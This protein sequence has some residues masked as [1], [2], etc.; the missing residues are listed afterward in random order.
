MAEKI[1]IKL[2]QLT[3]VKKGEYKYD[4]ELGKTIREVESMKD[5]EGEYVIE[6]IAEKGTNGTLAFDI[7]FSRK[8]GHLRNLFNEI[9]KYNFEDVFTEA[10]SE[11]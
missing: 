7:V 8:L 3:R 4:E 11:E 1:N 9:V 2:P 6:R 5:V 10:V